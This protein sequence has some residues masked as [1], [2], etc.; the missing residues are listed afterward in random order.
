MLEVR[1]TPRIERNCIS[2]PLIYSILGIQPFKMMKLSFCQIQLDTISTLVEVIADQYPLLSWQRP[3]PRNTV[4][5]RVEIVEYL[6]SQYCRA[7]KI[8]TDRRIKPA[9]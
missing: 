9:I 2:D 8:G 5:R 7:G 4:G 3:P 6:S 1:F